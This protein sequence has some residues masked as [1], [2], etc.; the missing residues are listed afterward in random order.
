MNH[1]IR[2]WSLQ[3]LCAAMTLTM[4]TGCT[5]P[6]KHTQEQI[7]SVNYLDVFDTVTTIMGSA[8][9]E[10]DFQEQAQQIHQQLMDLH[11]LFD[12]YHDYDGI[13]NLKTINDQAGIS[14]VK[15][16]EPILS[17][18]L[19]CR[20]YN[21][22]TGG[23]VNAAMGS[24]LS[25]WH[26]ARTAGIDSPETA[27]LP[28]TDALQEAAQ[29]TDFD[30][31]IISEAE[32]TVYLSDPQMKLDVGAIAK[33]WA[34]QRAVETAPEGFLIS[35]GGNV[36]ATGSKFPDGTPWTVGVQNPDGD[37]DSYVTAVPLTEGSMV[38]SGD[39]QRFFTV[40]GV[41]YHHIIDPDT[42]FPATRWRSVTILCP[43]SGLADM[44]S[45]ALFLLGQQEGQALLDQFHAEALWIDHNGALVR[46]PGFPS[47]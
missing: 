17:L 27:Y 42:L 24:V 35:V 34:A 6:A 23:K 9:S 8:E 15:V 13:T 40:D 19:D 28:D 16:E 18:L 36:L 21:E 32:S 11:R 47:A 22:A 3:L 1:T 33:G 26:D 2:K 7:Y 4:L 44:L 20:E 31:V 39:Y 10:T 25:L 30:H 43:D 46:S 14:P 45:T 37:G 29:H 5:A 41:R 38:T 12:I